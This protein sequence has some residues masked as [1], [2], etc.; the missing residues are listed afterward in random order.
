[1]K[2]VMIYGGGV[3]GK[4]ALKL[5]E[6]EGYDV[7]LV[8][9]KVGI[10]SDE[11]ISFLNEVEF[12]V[13]SPGI[14]YNYLVMEA[15]K[16]KIEVIDE[17][18]LAYRFDKSE[19]KIIAITGTN[20]K[21][22]TTSKI[23]GLIKEAGFKVE[24]GGNI[25]KS[26][27]EI[28]VENT[29]LDYIVLE[30]SSYQ[31]EN[32]KKFR[33]Y[34]ALIIN[35]SPDHLDR[36]ESLEA[37]YRAKANITKNQTSEDYFIYNKDSKE[38]SEL[39]IDFRASLI[40]V[41]SQGLKNVDYYVENGQV[42]NNQ[43]KLLEIERL[44]LKGKHNLENIM[45]VLAVCDILKIDRKLIKSYLYNTEPLEHRMEIVLE[46]DGIVFVNDSKGTNIDS[47]IKAIEAYKENPILICGGKD[48]AV[49][50]NPLADC[51]VQRVKTLYLMGQTGDIIEELVR[52]RGYESVYNFGTLEK[53]IENIVVKKNDIVLFSPAHSSFDQFANYV[54]R[55]KE[56]KRLVL[57]KFNKKID[58]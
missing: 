53:I 9:D 19:A 13:K 30:L 11:A 15:I 3:S 46:K 27:S 42:K 47:T 51:I 25:G 40:E 52:K 44:S 48:K 32:I 4:G 1:M 18:E 45:F 24:A 28:I 38:I 34:I 56:F 43:E 26:Y 36:Y 14:P 49:D 6:R 41:S 35:L 21:T 58:I 20:G 8:D 54:E 33:P 17:I 10:K 39:S 16:R 29:N 7:L 23:A 57:L 31:L 2:K 50:L 37:Y 5:L 22:T 12:F 55:G